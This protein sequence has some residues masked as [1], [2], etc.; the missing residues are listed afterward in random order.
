MVPFAY[1]LLMTGIPLR[2]ALVAS[3]IFGWGIWGTLLY[4]AG[5]LGVDPY[6]SDK[7]FKLASEVDPFIQMGYDRRQ[8]LALWKMDHAETIENFL[9]MLGVFVV[10]VLWIISAGGWAFMLDLIASWPEW[11]FYVAAI[12]WTFVPII[13]NYIYGIA[14][15]LKIQTAGNM[16]RTA[17]NMEDYYQANN[18]II[19]KPWWLNF[20]PFKAAVFSGMRHRHWLRWCYLA[21]TELTFRER[22]HNTYDY[23]RFLKRAVDA[24]YT[25][26]DKEFRKKVLLTPIH[27]GWSTVIA[28]KLAH[29]F[30][31]NSKEP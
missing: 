8:L 18:P 1:A 24:W 29:R 12:M 10:M 19:I 3:T 15:G 13:G 30:G 25:F 20:L 17:F 5:L 2:S 14:V 21:V 23:P 31:K 6:R 7:G 26:T 9:G 4:T 28:A 16:L 11:L 22:I 27:Y